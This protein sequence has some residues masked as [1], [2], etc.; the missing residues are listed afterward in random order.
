M[1]R[2][3]NRLDKIVMALLVLVL[4]VMVGV[5]TM[6]VVSRYVFE[7]SLSWSEELMRYLY[8][9]ATMLGLGVAIRRK[10]FASID[11]L[12]DFVGEK[13]EA[14]KRT[15]QLASIILQLA[16]FLLLIVY[17]GSYTMRGL[18]QRSP[19]ML[20]QMAYIYAAF[21][22]GGVLGL[23]F[24]VEEGYNLFLP[25]AKTEPDPDEKVTY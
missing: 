9:W 17:G 21:P 10:S 14:A 5:G 22:V 6:Q 16:V 8:V 4:T 18:T 3:L 13:S 19:A 23:I 15:M 1:R 11:S 2:A 12:V 24:T 25:K 20:I 7:A